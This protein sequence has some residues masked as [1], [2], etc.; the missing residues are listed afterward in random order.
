MNKVIKISVT[1]DNDYNVGMRSTFTI[2]DMIFTDY[3]HLLSCE[4][5]TEN[6]TLALKQSKGFTMLTIDVYSYDSNDY[7]FKNDMILGIRYLCKYGEITK[8]NFK[9]NRYENWFDA[10]KKDI[11]LDLKNSVSKVNDK[12]IEFLKLA[13][14]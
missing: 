13:T 8:A 6:L 2:S 11:F 5:I 9:N 1:I 12:Y 10:T 14:V 7:S 4:A 3:S